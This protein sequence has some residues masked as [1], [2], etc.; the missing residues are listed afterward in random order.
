MPWLAPLN[1]APAVEFVGAGPGHH[2]EEQTALLGHRAAGA[3]G[4]IVGFLE[5]IRIEIHGGHRAIAVEC[6]DVH[7][8]DQKP[9]SLLLP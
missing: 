4:L 6:G 8:V 2:V 5:R 9:F 7:A 3:S 1:I